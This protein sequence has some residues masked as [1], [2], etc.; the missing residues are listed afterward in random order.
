M[1]RL[2]KKKYRLL[3]FSIEVSILLV[4]LFLAYNS[5]SFPAKK[6]TFYLKDSNVSTLLDTLNKN[7]YMTY[8]IDKLTLALVPKVK[9]GWYQL[10]EKKQGRFQFLNTLHTHHV[11]SIN[12]KVYAGE[13]TQE[14]IKRL[15]N[16]MKLD[17]HTLLSYYNQRSLY[18]EANIF[19]G[20]YSLPR[21]ADENTTITILF[22]VS[23][24]MFEAFQTDFC[25]TQISKEDM[26][27][28][29]TMASII[30]K[31]SNN[32][33][34][35]PL[36]GSVIYNRLLKGMKLQMDGTLNYGKYSHTVVTSERIKHDI[37]TYNTYKYKGIPPHPL[38][39]V[40]IEALRAAYHPAQTEYLFFMLNRDG[41]HN[42]AKTY[43]EHLE[44]VRAFKKKKTTDSNTSKSL[45]PS[46]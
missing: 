31:E 22:D 2:I 28:F 36:I 5:V 35:M 46:A 33:Q 14:L 6:T 20:S 4:A 21:N 9:K 44:N 45:K 15:A 32:V 7:G 43:K 3:V 23:N 40:S 16:D 11:S 17:P 18:K 30:Q 24:Q 8:S 41:S 27:I 19:S 38:S 34:E 42:F 1:R 12:I 39:T 37:S 13:T 26:K 10:E 25:H 29:L